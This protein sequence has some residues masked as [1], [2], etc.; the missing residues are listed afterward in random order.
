MNAVAAL[1]GLLYLTT[2]YSL[3]GWVGNPYTS[4]R[5]AFRVF[6]ISEQVG[7]KKNQAAL[8]QSYTLASIVRAGAL[9]ENAI[10]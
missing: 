1:V 2:H 5:A 6:C 8:A 7:S 10:C 4:P 3:S 9:A